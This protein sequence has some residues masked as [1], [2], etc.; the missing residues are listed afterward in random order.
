MQYIVHR[1]YKGLCMSGP[2]NIPYG[3]ICEEKDGTIYHDGRPLCYDSSEDACQFFARNDDGLGLQ[4]GK[5]TQGIQKALRLRP[6][7]TPAQRDERWARTV[8]ED[9]TCQQYRMQEHENTWIWSVAFYRAP[10]LD[11]QHISALVGAGKG[12]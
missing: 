11:L 5:L 9:A 4:R 6:G 12:N 7:E 2:V 8:W 3:T 1:R 10:L